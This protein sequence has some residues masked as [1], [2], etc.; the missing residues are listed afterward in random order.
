MICQEQTFRASAA[1]SLRD[2]W[3]KSAADHQKLFCA[4]Q[5]QYQ[6]TDEHIC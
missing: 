4:I 1:N 6:P 3:Q 2:S 5:C